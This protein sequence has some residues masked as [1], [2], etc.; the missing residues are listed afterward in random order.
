MITSPNQKLDSAL[1]RILPQS[2]E[3]E[4]AILGGILLDPNAIERVLEILTPDA[5]YMR[6]HRFLYEVTVKLHKEGKP[7]DMIN[8]TIWLKDHDCLDKVGGQAQISRLVDRTFSAANIDQHAE[9]VMEKWLRRQLLTLGRELS[10]RVYNPDLS[11]EEIA[12]W[13]NKRTTSVATH[14][15]DDATPLSEVFAVIAPEMQDN[16]ELTTLPGIPT[17]FYELDAITQG[18]Q[19]GDLIYLAGRPS[20]G[21][22]GALTNIARNISTVQKMPVLLFS[23][24]M[25]A[26]SLAYR[27]T[28]AEIEVDIAQLRSGRLDE[29]EWQAFYE[30]T[31]TLTNKG[32]DCLFLETGLKSIAEMRAIA[33]RLCAKVGPLG[34]IGIDYIQLMEMGQNRVQELGQISSGLK[35][36][37]LDFNCPVIALSQLSRA[38]ELRN[39]KR[40]IMSDLRDS[41]NLEQDADLIIMLYRDECYYPGTSDQ[42]IAELNIVK[43]RNGPIGTVK[44]RFDPQFTRFRN[45]ETS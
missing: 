14:G 18:L 10:E 24:E 13:I 26:S 36:I 6:A 39:N 28:S 40:P 34:L 41:G 31:E 3:V 30:A 45:L 2:L 32:D 20:M 25:A 44:L 1:E 22:T 21:K 7:T 12:D 42:G 43:H 19:R 27:L 38:L 23:M 9:L 5:F 37:A 16:S 8:V 33:K 29:D 17:G 4:E 35:A 11:V 15:S